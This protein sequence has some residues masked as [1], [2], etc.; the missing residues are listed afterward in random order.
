MKKYSFEAIGAFFLTLATLLSLHSEGAYVAIAPLIIGCMLAAMV[1]AG[2]PISGAHF[3]PIL[4]LAALL[5]S[6]ITGRTFGFYAAA[7]FLGATMAAF[8]AK[9][10][11]NS[12]GAPEFTPLAAEPLPALVAEVAGAFALTHVVLQTSMT[13]VQTGNSYFGIAIGCCY[14]ALI[15]VLGRY[16]GGFFNP[17]IGLGNAIAGAAQWSDCWIY[18]V[19]STIGAAAATTIFNIFGEEGT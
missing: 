18:L 2:F 11:L 1:Y 13:K 5:R 7:Q 12:T 17:A 6:K 15:A 10:L 4:S 8:I 9:F 19:G 16:T 3:N 14:A